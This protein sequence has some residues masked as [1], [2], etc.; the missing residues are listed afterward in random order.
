MT[1]RHRRTST[2]RTVTS[3]V[4]DAI[5]RVYY[6][7]VR[8][9]THDLSPH[10][11]TMHD[12]SVRRDASTMRDARDALLGSVRHDAV[13]QGAVRRCTQPAGQRTTH[14]THARCTTQSDA[15]CYTPRHAMPHRPV[16]ARRT[17][18]H[19]ATLSQR[20]TSVPGDT[21]LQR[22]THATCDMVTGAGEVGPAS[23]RLP[24]TARSP[25]RNT[26]RTTRTR[27]AQRTISDAHCHTPRHTTVT[28]RLSHQSTHDAHDAR[29]VLA[30]Q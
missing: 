1:T 18:T 27:D 22:A 2:R 11:G 3:T 9:M 26:Q 5:R 28:T 8:R 13:R 7:L 4:H 17:A 24:Y 16:D 10:V 14:D 25:L 20:T 12:D 30:H 23:E 21:H 29:R 19:G 15:R 6:I